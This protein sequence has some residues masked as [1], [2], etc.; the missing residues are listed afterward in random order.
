M[1]LFLRAELRIN[2]YLAR[3]RKHCM[4]FFFKYTDQSR[5]ETDQ[6]GAQSSQFFDDRIR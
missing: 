2:L 6:S 4:I 1:K 5:T 3:V